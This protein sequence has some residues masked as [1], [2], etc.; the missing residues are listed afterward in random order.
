MHVIME[1]VSIKRKLKKA[2]VEANVFMNEEVRRVVEKYAGPFNE[3]LKENISVAQEEGLPLCQDTGMLEFFVF[4]GHNVRIDQPI[5]SIINEAVEEAYL[6]NPFRFSIVSDP[7]F[8]RKNTGNNVPAVIHVMPVEGNV[9][10]IRFLV[11]GGG[12][13]N[14]SRL[15]MLSPGADIDEVKTRII[16]HVKN[17]GAMACPPLHVGIG[18]GGSSDKAMLLSKLALTKDLHERN[19]DPRYARL[20]EELLEELNGLRIGFQGLGKGPTVLSVHIEWS[21][22]H[23]A[24][25]PLAVSVDCYLCRKGRI[26]LEDR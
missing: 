5:E 2:I 4:Q 18:V 12:S 23:I 1:S 25:L 8:S 26:L 3:A 6:E 15:Y 14:L 10:D 7:L 20:E 9:L 21:P 13:E 24:T 16:E 22:T 17:N 19:A 11:K